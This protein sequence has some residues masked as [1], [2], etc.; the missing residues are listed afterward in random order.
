MIAI[1]SNLLLRATLEK[2]LCNFIQFIDHE[3]LR[4]SLIKCDSQQ[5]C[6]LC[7]GWRRRMGHITST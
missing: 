7:H 4:V 3:D 1:K 6:N 5:N 2:M